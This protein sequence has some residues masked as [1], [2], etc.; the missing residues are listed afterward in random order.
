MLA[1]LPEKWP[2]CLINYQ[3]SRFIFCQLTDLCSSRSPG[4]ST[5]IG[6]YFS[7]TQLVHRM[8]WW[9]PVDWRLVLTMKFFNVK[10]WRWNCWRCMRSDQ[11]DCLKD[12]LLSFVN[13]SVFFECFFLYKQAAL[14][15][16]IWVSVNKSYQSTVVPDVGNAMLPSGVKPFQPWSTTRHSSCLEF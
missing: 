13:E 10:G 16:C 7:C 11:Y 5:L 4:C 15:V 14:T 12:R 6:A 2:E 3:Y 8:L 1:F 9:R